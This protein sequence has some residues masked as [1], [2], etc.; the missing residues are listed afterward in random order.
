MHDLWLILGA[1][2]AGAVIALFI[3]FLIDLVGRASGN[4]G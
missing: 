1:A 3:V 2:A 4:G